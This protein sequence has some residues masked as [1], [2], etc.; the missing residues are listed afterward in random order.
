MKRIALFSLAAV[1]LIACRDDATEP[2]AVDSPGVPV[3]GL[4]NPDGCVAPPSDLVSWW[5]GEAD[6]TDVAGGHDGSLV[7]G[8]T[9][10]AGQ[11][12]LAFRFDAVGEL[13]EVADHP[14][15]DIESFP[16]ATVEGWFTSSGALGSDPNIVGKHTC[17]VYGGWFFTTAQGAFIGNH[18]V[19]G[20]GVK[21]LNLNDGQFH[22]FAI[23]KDGNRYFEYVDGTLLSSD[24]GLSVGSPAR[25][26]MQI[27]N[28]TT[29]TCL[30]SQHPLHG[31]VDEL[32]IYHRALSA[33]EIY[34]IFQAGSA[35]KCIQVDIDVKPG[36]D[37]NCFNINGRGVIPVAILGSADF[38]VSEIDVGTLLF[39]GLAVRVRGKG[40][41]CHVED[42]NGDPFPD[43]VC[44]FEDNADNWEEGNATAK[45]T[46]SLSNGIPFAGTDNICVVP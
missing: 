5:P 18:W 24:V 31:V 21:G 10:E 39:G 13:V 42:T 28:I 7:G 29:G 14:D 6:A 26:P 41:L 9:F 34:G 33:S 3:F 1:A 25:E 19:G 45:L 38:D 36:S 11:A 46:G 30:A 32:T 20:Q 15:L 17:S 8:V 35:G 16:S 23:V 37:P 12:G 2:R 40:P 44:Q 4:S 27:G 22:H 43:L